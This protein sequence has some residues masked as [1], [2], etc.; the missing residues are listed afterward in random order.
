MTKTDQTVLP[1]VN[2]LIIEKLKQY[3][4]AVSEMAIK[5]IQL[6]EELPEATVYEAL[7]GF[8]RDLA[9]RNGDDL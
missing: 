8:V 1:D 3:S 6:S 4:P 5:A 7:Q 9:R 2:E